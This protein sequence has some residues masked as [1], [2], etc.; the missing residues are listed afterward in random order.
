MG[1]SEVEVG[2]GAVKSPLCWSAHLSVDCDHPLDY[3]SQVFVSLDTLPGHG[4]CSIH[5]Y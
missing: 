2:V 3:E 1:W 5:V 4:I